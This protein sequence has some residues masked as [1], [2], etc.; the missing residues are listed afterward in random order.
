[1]S[2]LSNKVNHEFISEI[3]MSLDTEQLKVR[4]TDCKRRFASKVCPKQ[5]IKG[6]FKNLKR[7]YFIC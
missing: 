6:A 5:V 1:M 2:N 3:F 4:E 7:D